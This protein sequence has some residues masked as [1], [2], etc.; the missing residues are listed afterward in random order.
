[1]KLID[2]NR[3]LAQLDDSHVLFDWAK[4]LFPICRSI[5]GNGVRQTLDFINA[6]LNQK[7]Q[8][9]EVATGTQVFDWQIPNEWNI[10]DAWVK[11]S[12][13][14]KIIDFAAHNLHIVNYS[15]PINTHLS[16]AELQPYLHSLPDQPDAIPYVTSYYKE[17]WGFCLSD[18]QRKTLKDDNY[19]VFIDSSL[20]PGHLS[21]G[22]L[23]LPGQSSQEILIS[24]YTCHPS[25]GNNELSGPI[26]AMAL[27]RWLMQQQHFYTYRFVFGPETIGALTYLSQHLEHFKKH[28]KAGFILTCLGDNGPY[29]MVA[30][31]YANTLADKIV[32]ATYCNTKNAHIYS[33]LERGSDERQYGAPGIELPVVTLSRSRFGLFEQYHTSKDDLNY[34]SAQGLHSSLYA[35]AD[36]L[37]TLEN[38]HYYQINCLGE[39]QLGKRGL[40]PTLSTKE[41]GKSIRQMM[42]FIT[43][44]D[45]NNDLLDI[46]EL[47]DSRPELLGEHIENLSREK[48]LHFNQD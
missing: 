18:E 31:R 26:V 35:I 17:R 39:P 33:F 24:T 9:Y 23:V 29:S 34:I 38:N 22:D 37:I 2:R 43:Y 44:C 47:I 4:A 14:N 30:S 16:L 48:L 13:G 1:M 21:Y 11:D 7:L 32:K 19:H 42:N 28:L 3:L 36:M 15:T 8:R 10:K 6:Q 20:K 46:C 45:G 5:T 27:A 40:Y 25:M 12:S 41:S